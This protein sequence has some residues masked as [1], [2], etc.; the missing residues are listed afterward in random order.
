MTAPIDYQAVLADLEER[1]G[2]LDAAIAAVRLIMS[3]APG[4]AQDPD[5]PPREQVVTPAKQQSGSSGRAAVDTDTFFGLSTSNAV[6]K[7]LSIAKR[8][9]SGQVHAVDPKTAYTNVYTALKR[10]KDREFAQ[11]RNGEWGLA[12]WYN[13]KP[14]GDSD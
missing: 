11:T 6:K 1:R 13:N 4:V 7:F 14:K 9:Q 8:P 3:G 10:G 12:E 2:Q 5:A